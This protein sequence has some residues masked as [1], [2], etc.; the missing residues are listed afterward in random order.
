MRVEYLRVGNTVHAE[1]YSDTDFEVAAIY[2]KEHNWIVACK[3]GKNGTWVNPVELWNDIPVTEE[4]LKQYGFIEI[5][6][7]QSSGAKARWEL[8]AFHVWVYFEGSKRFYWE[9]DRGVELTSIH[10]L[11]NLYFALE[12]KELKK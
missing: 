5:Q 1:D 6:T 7:G 10:Q 3:G 4:R 12:Q 11:Q 8:G 9:R 2:Q